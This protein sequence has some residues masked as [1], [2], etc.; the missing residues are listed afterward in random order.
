[1]FTVIS[2]VPPEWKVNS[3][4]NCY[5]LKK[6]VNCNISYST[7]KKCLIWHSTFTL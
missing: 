5:P 2:V 6:K 7:W 3:N 4:I 1:M